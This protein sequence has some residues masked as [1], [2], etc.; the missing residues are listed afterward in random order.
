MEDIFALDFLVCF[1]FT[2]RKRQ[3]TYVN[4]RPLKCQSSVDFCKREASYLDPIF[5][6]SFSTSAI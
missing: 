4:F 5:E 2:L 1:L 3:S 6:F